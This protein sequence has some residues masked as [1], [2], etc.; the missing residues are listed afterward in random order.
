MIHPVASAIP[1][2]FIMPARVRAKQHT[3][4]QSAVQF[5][6]H[7]RQLL[8][9]DMKQRGVGKHAVEIL[10]RQLELEEILLPYVAAATGACH[11][12]KMHGAFQTNGDVTLFGKH[13]EVAPWS[14]AKIEYRE[15][16]LTV[17]MLQQHINVLADVVIAR[18]FPEFFGTLVVVLKRE[19]GDFL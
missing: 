19:V 6:Q 1:A 15:R 10:F 5:Q 17:N 13:F 8:A 14:A 2:F 4:L 11:C 18:A 3:T 16:R 7:P 12:G 9:R